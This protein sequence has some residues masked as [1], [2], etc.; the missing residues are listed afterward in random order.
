[1]KNKLF[2]RFSVIA[3]AVTVAA[4][5]TVLPMASFAQTTTGTSTQAQISFLAGL[6]QQIQALQQQIQNLKQQQQTATASLVATL[7]LGS[8]GDQVRILQALLAADPGVYP[9]GLITGLFGPATQ[10]AVK[11]FQ[12]T[13]G[14]EQAGVVGP[15]TL[16]RLNEKLKEHPVGLENS[17]STKKGEKGESE[18]RGRLCAI[19]PPGHLIAPGWLR[20]NDGVKPIVPQCQTLPPGIFKLLN[21]TSTPTSTATLTVTNVAAINV[22]TSSA[23]ITWTSNLAANSQVSY[24]LTSAYGSSTALDSGLVVLHSQNL[25][26]LTPGTVYHFKVM[27]ANTSAGAASGDMTFTT[28]ALDVAPPVISA[29]TNSA[30]STSATVSWVTNEPAT[31]KVYFGTINPLDLSATTTMSASNA[32]LVTSH[33]LTLSG[34]TASTTYLFVVQ[35]ADGSGNGVT[36]SQLSLTTTN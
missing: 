19:V 11:R 5:G 12:K 36:S 23:T 3:V 15:K 24:G 21:G 33:A 8:Q 6:M 35:S 17:S 7:A 10:R 25:T 22:A 2:S 4:A 13:H 14:L 9:E 29:I 16:A 26:G 30:A 20:K 18:G 32:T 1:M 28:T 27:S 34:L 31:S